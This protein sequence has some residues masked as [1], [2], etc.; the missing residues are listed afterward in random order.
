MT[1]A[2][3]GITYA[4]GHSLAYIYLEHLPHKSGWDLLLP[5]TAVRFL[6]GYISVLDTIMV[7]VL[8]SLVWFYLTLVILI[9]QQWKLVKRGMTAFEKENGMKVV[10]RRDLMENVRGVFGR[11]WALNFVVPLHWWFPATDDGLDWSHI[12]V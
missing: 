2:A 5:L 11:Y 6:L 1:W 10:N 4:L 8:Y 9:M 3:L 7:V 12:A